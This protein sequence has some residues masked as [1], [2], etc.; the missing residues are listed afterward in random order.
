MIRFAFLSFY[1]SLTRQP[2]Y[3]ALNL[4]GL[5]L[6]I[7]VF[8]ALSLFVRFERSYDS[9]LPHAGTIYSIAVKA[10]FRRTHDKPPSYAAIAP[11]FD[12]IAPNGGAVAATRIAPTYVTIKTGNAAFSEESQLV[13]PDFFRVFDLPVVAGDRDAALKAPDGVILTESAART[14][15]GRTDIVGESVTM[16]DG[17]TLSGDSGARLEKRWRVTAVLKDLPPN[18]SLKISSIRLISPALITR[19][20]MWERLSQMYFLFASPDRANDLAGR[21]PA[22][23]TAHPYPQPLKTRL[24]E[25]AAS[26]TFYVLP[27]TG[28]HL[29][30]PH[31]VQALA[32]LETAGALAL[33]VALANYIN[34]AAVRMRPR[35]REVAVRKATG[36]GSGRLVAQFLIEAVIFGLAAIMIAL[37]LVEI[38]LPVIDRIGRLPLHLD[39][40]R[41]APIIVGLAVVAL[42]CTGLAGLYPAFVLAAYAPAPVL[43]TAKMP[44]GRP[45]GRWLREGLALAQFAVTTT[46][47]IAII[48]FLTQVAHMQGNDIGIARTGVLVTDSLLGQGLSRDEAQ[49]VQTAWRRTPGVQAVSSG[50]VPGRY[51]LQSLVFAPARRRDLDGAPSTPANVVWSDQDFFKAYDTRVLAGRPL[52]QADDKWT[53]DDGYASA[54]KIWTYP[55]AANVAVDLTAAQALGFASP[56]AALGHDIAYGQAVLHIVGVVADQRF[57]GPTVRHFPAIYLYSSLQPIEQDTIIRYSGID[58]ATAT[59]R[60][61]VA[62]HAAVPQLPLQLNGIGHELD[63]FYADDRR[64][65]RLFALGGIV[66]GLIGAMGL[67]AMAAFNASVRVQE[68]GIRKSLGAS[69]WKIARLLAVQSLRPVIVANLIAWPAAWLILDRWLGQFEDRV[70]LSPWFFLAGSGVSL[71][72]AVITVSGVAWSAARVQPGGAL[73]QV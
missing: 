51:A 25:Y 57:H 24:D 2:L 3:A 42:L 26:S 6:G 48:G 37:S 9:W 5:S 66:A 47:F 53:L 16:I 36:A 32:A 70:A 50:L 44:A 27:L 17:P 52:T 59:R 60:L 18:T 69:P 30:D 31:A 39:Y 22:L 68:F 56:Q 19:D 38:S 62:W 33:L 13:D 23:V 65:T 12:A 35:A 15:F 64:N 71:L 72:I 55:A 45:E 34:L 54:G 58:E 29:A 8:L 1:R 40:G 49:A 43:A 11:V 4:L 63:Y 73:Q 61:G 46:F 7:A 28:E 10:E 21:I 14:Y 41:E 20:I 67:Y